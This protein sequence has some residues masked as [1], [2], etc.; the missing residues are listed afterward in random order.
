MGDLR[1]KE[2]VSF[3]EFA[4]VAFELEA[5]K[6][7]LEKKGLF[8]G[9]E[10]EAEKGMMRAEVDKEAAIDSLLKD[11]KRNEPAGQVKPAHRRPDRG[12]GERTEGG[13]AIEHARLG[14]LH[15]EAGEYER[16]MAS[17]LQAL[18]LYNRLGEKENAAAML[19]NMASV[20]F[21]REHYD[22]A[23]IFAQRALGIFRELRQ[24]EAA[25]AALRLL[26]EIAETQK[27]FAGARKLYEE[28]LTIWRRL[29]SDGGVLA[30]LRSLADMA[31][32]AK[33]T[34]RAKE[35]YDEALDLARKL[36]DE[37]VTADIL[38]QFRKLE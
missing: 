9:K 32:E 20:E 18:A 17:Y 7:L 2:H 11:A 10:L 31:A 21:C 3:D 4:S 15:L 27:D 14:G 25:A 37:D 5:I 22:K 19:S 12:P 36:G 23:R 38:R 29:K 30:A 6:R 24:Q 8:S 35:L 28:C 26:A 13:A 1:R 33:E 16:A 34:V